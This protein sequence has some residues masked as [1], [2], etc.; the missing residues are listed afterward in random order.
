MVELRTVIIIS[1]L[2]ALILAVTGHNKQFSHSRHF[3]GGGGSDSDSHGDVHGSQQ[4]PCTNNPK[5]FYY[6]PPCSAT[7]TQST[8][9]T[10]SSTAST[11]EDH[12][13]E[14]IVE[15][16]TT[17]RSS[18]DTTSAP[19]SLER[20]HWCRSRNG[21]YVP[22]GYWYMNNVCTMCTCTKSRMIRCELLQCMPTYCVDNKMPYRKTG[23]CCT[24]CAYEHAENSTCE[25]NG[26]TFPHGAVMKA[27]E[28]KM[29]CWCQLGHI[30]CR[31]YIG[32]LFESLGLMADGIAIYVILMVLFVVITFGLLM[33]SGCTLLFYYY[34]KNNQCVIEQAYDQYVGSAGWQPV[35]EGEEDVVYT[36]AEEKLMEAE[37]YQYSDSVD[38]LVPPPYGDYNDSYA[39]EKE[40]NKL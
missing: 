14:E 37:K 2:M 19:T 3:G 4:R 5:M 29:Q 39:P 16:T 8:A 38:D 7:S 24:Q 36:G 11:T 9:T 23:Q 30:E 27:V 32:T 17:T 31:N 6:F 15:T 18:T 1:V 22:L 26:I 33:C 35:E 13:S 40:Q 25:Y 10:E 20:A 21:T 34:Y 28:N 12:S